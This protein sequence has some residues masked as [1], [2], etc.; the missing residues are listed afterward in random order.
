M[1]MVIENL[2]KIYINRNMQKYQPIIVG[3]SVNYKE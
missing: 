2:V 3:I 1:K